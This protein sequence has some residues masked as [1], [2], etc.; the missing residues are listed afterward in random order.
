MKSSG[1][2]PFATRTTLYPRFSRLCPEP[3]R[4]T[5]NCSRNLASSA[6]ASKKAKPSGVAQAAC[7]DVSIL[8]IRVHHGERCANVL[9][10]LASIATTAHCDEQLVLTR[11]GAKSDGSCEM[12]TSI[13]VIQPISRIGGQ[14]FRF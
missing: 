11:P 9:I 6:C 1:F 5:R 3:C 10:L 12:P 4:A 14:H 7:Q 13:F 8:P 2:S